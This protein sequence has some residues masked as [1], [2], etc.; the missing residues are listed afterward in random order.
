MK[1]LSTSNEAISVCV[2]LRLIFGNLE[3]KSEVSL[4]LVGCSCSG[5][6]ISLSHTAHSYVQLPFD[7]R[8]G[9]HGYSFLC[10]TGNSYSRKTAEVVLIRS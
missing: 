7:A 1:T 10:N 9:Q 8:I 3:T 5:A 2:E 6:S 4:M